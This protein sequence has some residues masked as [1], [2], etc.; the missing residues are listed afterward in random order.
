MKF[1]S[2]RTFRCL[3]PLPILLFLL[4]SAAG[5]FFVYPQT[6]E[7]IEVEV[8]HDT[9]LPNREPEVT[10]CLNENTI[11]IRED[12]LEWY[13]N[14][15]ACI[16]ACPCQECDLDTQYVCPDKYSLIFEE[17]VPVCVDSSRL[18]PLE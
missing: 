15:N 17:M 18:A 7:Q 8:E 12:V 10:I 4:I 16:C 1:P 14:H 5:I 6:V 11:N 3:A 13:L 9:Y 2:Q